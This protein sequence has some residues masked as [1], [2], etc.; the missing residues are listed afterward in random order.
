[1]AASGAQGLA[2]RAVI[3]AGTRSIDGRLAEDA[4]GHDRR[5]CR[6]R[7]PGSHRQVHCRLLDLGLRAGVL[8][9]PGGDPLPQGFNLVGGDLVA[10]G[11]HVRL[12]LVRDQRDRGTS[13]PDRRA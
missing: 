12:V 11:R 4:L 3:A 5:S 2:A 7:G 8:Q 13:R 10:A 6:P 1:M 9:G